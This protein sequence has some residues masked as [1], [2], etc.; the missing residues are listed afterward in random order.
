MSMQIAFLGAG[1]MA[2]ALAGGLISQDVFPAD[3][4]RAVDVSPEARSSF[5]QATGVDCFGDAEAALT[6][7]DVIV[8]A[9]KPQYAAGAIAPIAAN[10]G[11]ALIVSIAAGL[12]LE[13]LSKWFGHNRVVRVMPNTPAMVGL[14]AAVYSC[15]TG[16]TGVDKDLVD[17]VFQA[18]GIAMEMPEA[19]L[20]AVTALSG[21]GPAYMFE[22][23]RVMVLG[24][25][26]I[27]LDPEDALQLTTQTM[28]GAAQMVAQGFGSP[29]DLRIAVTSP[30]GTTAAGLSV[31]KEAG[32][33]E[34]M[35][36][37]LRA[38][39]DRSVELGNA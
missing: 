35:A 27:G 12:K 39:R 15:G 36:D 14:G 24:A 19:K 26:D 30:G 34:L 3:W 37:V 10:C 31:M 32:Y 38:A 29:E 21:S 8:I 25:V 16:V 23:I 5:T 1:K 4:I 7:A 2:T 22:L 28:M 11:R 13:T 17:R 33:T 6:D 18:V 20:D 9:V